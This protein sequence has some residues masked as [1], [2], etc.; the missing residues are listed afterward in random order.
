MANFCSKCGRPLPENGVCVCQMQPEAE[1]A[2]ASPRE[3]YVPPFP[4]AAAPSPFVT[5]LKQIV[6]FAKAFVHDPVAAVKQVVDEKNTGFSLVML[7][8]LAVA[9]VLS[10][11]TASVGLELHTDLGVIP[12]L[13]PLLYSLLF[14][15]VIAGLG[16]LGVYL[17]AR[18]AKQEVSMMQALT[19]VGAGSIVPAA[20]M[21]VGVLLNLYF[22]LSVLL[23]A[24]LAFCT[25]MT[26]C[27][28]ALRVFE[29]HNAAAIAVLGGFAALALL[30]GGYLYYHGVIVEMLKGSLSAAWGAMANWFT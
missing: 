5:A 10:W 9:S 4:Q 27:V 2:G 22:P 30:F 26:D 13:L 20:I 21:A 25:V 28:I 8:V 7:L 16:T 12:V 29:G 23:A 17:C 19:A 11:L 1:S 14:A 24:L 6:P 15:A 18:A 3:P